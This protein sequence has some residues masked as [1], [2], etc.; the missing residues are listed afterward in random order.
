MSDVLED[1]RLAESDAASFEA[2]RAERGGDL[3]AARDLYARASERT[4]S[5]A[6]ELSGLPRTRAIL[7][8]SAVCLAARAGRYDRAIS[9]AE[10]FLAEPGAIVDEGARELRALLVS[11]RETVAP[12]S[13]HA[14]PTG[15]RIFRSRREVRRRARFTP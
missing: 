13:R 2:E 9:L 4:A 8:V 11:Y 10:R 3:Y 5:V 12:T 14:H 15:S 7:A 6:L 1:P